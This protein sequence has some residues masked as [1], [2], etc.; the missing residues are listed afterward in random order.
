M[1]GACGERAV[2][3]WARP[4]VA[5]L[6]ARAS[7]ATAVSSLL[8]RAGPAVRPWGTGWLVSRPTGA[9]VACGSVTELVASVRPWLAPLGRFTP[10]RPSGRLAVPP[11]RAGSAWRPGVASVRVSEPEYAADLVAWLECGRQTG[12]PGV[13]ASCA[14][15]ERRTLHV[16]ARAGQVLH[17][18]VMEF[19]AG[20]WQGS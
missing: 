14:L 6:P 19:P 17:T 18:E 5:G 9:S 10:L 16:E 3:D 8:V 15:D 7:L 20:G 12:A 13:R 11:P 1:C 2:L 4:F